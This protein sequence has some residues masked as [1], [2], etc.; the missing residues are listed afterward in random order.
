MST[1]FTLT[2]DELDFVRYYC[3]DV[4]RASDGN[5]EVGPATKWLWDHG[6]FPTTMQPFQLAAQR[7]LPDYNA[8]LSQ[9]PF[10][11]FKP[12][13]STREEVVHQGGV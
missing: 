11:P 12:A 8:W 4:Y 5:R 10:P 7:S 13:W 3:Y 9:P 1:G 6:I 2:E